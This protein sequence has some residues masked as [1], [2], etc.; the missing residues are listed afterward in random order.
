ME[1]ELNSDWLFWSRRIK[2]KSEF[3]QLCNFDMFFFCWCK[4]YT[5]L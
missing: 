3:A 2:W 5:C 4:W 1:D